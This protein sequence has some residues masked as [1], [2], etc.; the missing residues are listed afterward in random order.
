[1]ILQSH[2]QITETEFATRQE[3]KITLLPIKDISLQRTAVSFT[4]VLSVKILGLQ[5]LYDLVS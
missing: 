4:A 2:Q 5:H 3:K 1:M